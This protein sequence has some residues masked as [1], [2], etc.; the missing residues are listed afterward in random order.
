MI[1]LEAVAAGTPGIYNIAD[2]DPA[3]VREW[4]P[5]LAQ[6]VGARPPLRVPGWVGRLAAVRWSGISRTSSATTLNGESKPMWRAA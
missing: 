4:L 6:V 3:P 5:Y 2:D 1:G